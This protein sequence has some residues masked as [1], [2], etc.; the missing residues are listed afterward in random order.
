VNILLV[1]SLYP[2]NVQG[3][4][5]LSV[6]AL[7]VGLAG[8]GHTV[9][10]LTVAQGSGGAKDVN[11]ADNISVHFRIFAPWSG[12]IGEGG[13]GQKLLL[14]VSDL[15]GQFTRGPIRRELAGQ[16]FDIVHTNALTGISSHI[17]R[18]AA[19]AGIPIVHTLRDYY[20]LC[21]R[22]TM[23]RK[24]ANCVAQCLSCRAVSSLR[25]RGLEKA[26]A[27]LGISQHI[28]DVHERAGVISKNS[29]RA[30]ITNARIGLP[31]KKVRRHAHGARVF[32]YLG[33]LHYSKGIETLISSF[34][35][36]PSDTRLRI[37]GKGAPV[38]EDHL[39]ALASDNRIE[40]LGFQDP[41][42]FLSSIDVLV[43]PSEWPEPLGRVIFEAYSNGIPVIATNHGGIPEIVDEGITGWLYPPKDQAALAGLLRQ[44]M[45]DDV[46]TDRVRDMCFSKAEGFTPDRC[47]EAHEAIYARCRGSQRSLTYSASECRDGTK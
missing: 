19:R 46:L 4:A 24:G 12:V 42:V 32:G 27:V 25:T 10:V 5:E 11:D 14:N 9:T 1:N 31:P 22:G 26:A 38:Y 2:P 33:R 34:R 40:F 21:L 44:A 3:G 6:K 30:V 37:A 17:W 13:L 39:K 36:L 23:L 28:L 29:I 45:E 8:R 7:S 16:R 43:V 20:L 47:A 35:T 41:D 18:E 15:F